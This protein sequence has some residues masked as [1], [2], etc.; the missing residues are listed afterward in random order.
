M[1]NIYKTPADFYNPHYAKHGISNKHML[2]SGPTG[3]GK[4]NCITNLI[5][6][7]A[8]TFRRIII[9]CKMT[10]E[11]IYKML[12]A[13][14]KDALQIMTLS[15]LPSLKNLEKPGQQLIIFD[16]FLT[17]SQKKLEDYVMYAR[18]YGIML[19]F[20]AQSFYA[21]S[22]FIRANISYLV[23][24]KM[25]NAKNTNLIV[26]TLGLSIEKETVTK[27]IKNA[28]KHELNICIIDIAN[29][30]MNK[31]I[32]RNW[33]EYYEIEDEEGEPINDVKLYKETGLLN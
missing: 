26:S 9:V 7:M 16:D 24:L 1:Y 21:T 3:S 10:D 28:T 30:N 29:G 12:K 18:K 25:T 11:K 6:Q 14:L 19:A 17:D 22:V 27:I 20:L 32:R 15:E 13:K 23:L 2:I 8:D 31:K 4:S 33:D 5:I